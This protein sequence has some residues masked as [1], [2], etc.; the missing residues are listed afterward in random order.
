M[1]AWRSPHLSI[2]W[3][4]TPASE[5]EITLNWRN[6]DV[7]VPV[8]RSTFAVQFGQCYI[9]VPVGITTNRIIHSVHVCVEKIIRHTIAARQSRR[10]SKS[11]RR[12]TVDDCTFTNWLATSFRVMWSWSNGWN[13]P[14]LYWR[15]CIWA[16]LS[17]KTCLACQTNLRFAKPGRG[18]RTR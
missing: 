11:R 2:Y 5:A 12:P 7:K 15:C 4:F 10:S 14:R 6:H 9:C 17:I 18:D 1:A 13:R 16:V 3:D 8:T